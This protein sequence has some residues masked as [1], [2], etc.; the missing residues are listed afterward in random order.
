MFIEILRHIVFIGW[1]VV[2]KTKCKIESYIKYT[3]IFQDVIVVEDD[4]LPPCS[5]VTVK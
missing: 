3:I 2:L 5:L 4:G 1:Q